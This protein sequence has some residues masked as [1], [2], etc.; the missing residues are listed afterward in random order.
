MRRFE[1]GDCDAFS[2]LAPSFDLDTPLFRP[3]I[4]FDSRGIFS[5]TILSG[6]KVNPVG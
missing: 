2:D 6:M 5:E 3:R 1:F 4:D